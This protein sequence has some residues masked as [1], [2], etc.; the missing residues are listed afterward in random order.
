MAE[1]FRLLNFESSE[2]DRIVS[3]SK[4][5]V[6]MPQLRREFNGAVP[7]RDK[8]LLSDTSVVPTAGCGFSTE[9]NVTIAPSKGLPL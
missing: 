9:I 6:T 1:I 3:E 8:S 4:V 7:L 5:V 2:Y